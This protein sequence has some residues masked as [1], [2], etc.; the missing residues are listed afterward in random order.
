MNITISIEGTNL[1]GLEYVASL[2]KLTVTDY[3]QNVMNNACESYYKMSVDADITTIKEKIT[4]GKIAVADI[5]VL[6]KEVQEVIK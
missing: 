3:V 4:T 1:T 2:G 5:L 6:D